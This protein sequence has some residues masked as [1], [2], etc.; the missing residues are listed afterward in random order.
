MNYDQA[1]KLL[2]TGPDGIARWNRWRESGVEIPALTHADLGETF[3]SGADLRGAKLGGANLAAANL[4]D[5]VLRGANLIN[6]NLGKTLLGGADLSA[7]NLRGADLCLA[8]LSRATLSGANLYRVNLYNAGT[9]ETDF[10]EAVCAGTSFTNVDLSNAH[11]LE[12][13]TH[14]GPSSIGTDTLVRTKGRI[15]ETFLRGCG[16]A[17]WEVLVANLYRADLT[18]PRASELQY[19]IFDAW[20]KGRSLIN[21]CFVSYSWS[22]ASFVDNLRDRLFA[23]GINVWLDRHDAVAGTIQ[24]QVW[25]AIQFHHVVILVLSKRSVTSDWVE[26]ELEMAREKEKAEG[27]PVLCPIALD[28]SW[29]VKVEAKGSPGDPSRQLWRTLTQKLILKFPRRKT[30]SFEESLQKLVRGLNTN[31]GPR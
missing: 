8:D 17:P 30:K 15:P 2:R 26:N 14:D 20:T 31:Y 16:L 1:L 3:L 12:A 21:G 10:S 28:D 27:R 22:D 6:A 9:E 18:P 4:E 24:D 7:A 11:G 5:A 25:R 29:K 13:V 23:E 19:K